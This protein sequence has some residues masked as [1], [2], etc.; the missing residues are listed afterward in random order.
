MNASLSSHPRAARG[1]S[2]AASAKTSDVSKR[3]GVGFVLEQCGAG[4]L[5]KRGDVRVPISCPESPGTVG[6]AQVPT[7]A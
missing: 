1:E 6:I 7:E 5:A 2:C 4:A 3:A